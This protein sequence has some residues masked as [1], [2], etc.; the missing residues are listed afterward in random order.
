MQNELDEYDCVKL[1]KKRN[2]A[3]ADGCKLLIS[4]V[5][6]VQCNRDL[7]PTNPL[8]EGDVEKRREIEKPVFVVY[9][10][11]RLKTTHAKLKVFLYKN[12]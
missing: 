6:T 1:L 8:L 4:F 5:C 11:G 12:I 10:Q 2:S 9:V 7:T 3:I